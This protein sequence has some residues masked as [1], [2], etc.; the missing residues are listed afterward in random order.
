MRKWL[1]VVEG[2]FEGAGADGVLNEGR[3]RRVVSA[4]GTPYTIWEN[5]TADQ[6][7]AVFASATDYLRGLLSRD[8]R[9]LLVWD[10]YHA[11]HPDGWSAWH[12]DETGK[13]AAFDPDYRAQIPIYLSA[14]EV[15]ADPDHTD[16]VEGAPA[17]V[18]I[19]GPAFQVRAD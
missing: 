12:G 18:R 1:S 3:A 16:A 10:G 7:R 19:C 2:L 5:P 11:Q 14:D 4:T 9:R 17:L 8:G 6:M 13:L 15:I